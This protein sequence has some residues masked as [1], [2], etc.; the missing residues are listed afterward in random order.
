MYV[1][2]SSPPMRERMSARGAGGVVGTCAPVGDQ[3]PRVTRALQYISSMASVTGPHGCVW[4]NSG[5][6]SR[7]WE[8]SA[9][10]GDKALVITRGGFLLIAL[11]SRFS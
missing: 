6:V 9:E 8:L 5:F 10:I 7:Q 3:G 2:F 11:S 4:S 1:T